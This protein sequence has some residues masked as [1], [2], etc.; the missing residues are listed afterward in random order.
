MLKKYLLL[1]LLLFIQVLLFAQPKQ[2]IDSL[3]NILKSK[4]SLEKEAETLIAL[5]NVY[6]N[7]DIKLGYEYAEKAINMAAKTNNE[8]LKL[9]AKLCMA[10]VYRFV[11]RPD[12]CIAIC[13][14]IMSIARKKNKR[15]LTIRALQILGL[16]YMGLGQKNL[17]LNFYLE[18]IEIYDDELFKRETGINQWIAALYADQKKYDE[19]LFYLKKDLLIKSKEKN[20]ETAGTLS[21]IGNLYYKQKKYEQALEYYT[22]G[23]EEGKKIKNIYTITYTSNN[24]GLVKFRQKKYEEAILYFEES[25]E[26]A[27]KIKNHRHEGNSYS[28]LA[29]LYR[30]MKTYKKAIEYAEIGFKL[31]KQIKDVVLILEISTILV[32]IYEDINDKENKYLYQSQKANYQDTLIKQREEREFTAFELHQKM[33]YEKKENRE[34]SDRNNVLFFYTIISIIGILS[35]GIIVFLQFKRNK[36]KQE[37]IYQHDIIMTD[38]EKKRRLERELAHSE[39]VRLEEKT[40]FQARQLS[41]QATLLMQK[42]EWLLQ[43]EN[44]LKEL[45]SDM[46][47]DQ[48]RSIRKIFLET[49][50]AISLENDWDNYKNQFEQV[51]P[52]FFI[53]I[54]KRFPKTTN[55]D[56]R[57]AAYLKM[58]L[59]NG[60]IAQMLNITSGSLKVSFNRLKK[61]FELSEEQNLRGFIEEF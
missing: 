53:N 60:E 27:K 52:T 42:N 46:P 47:L 58:R 49:K 13:R 59:T 55:N 23:Y 34:L 61:K 57:L 32:D 35:L 50:E 43:I 37:V 28:N 54:Q 26:S 14:E 51:H 44:K 12:D 38:L 2:K 1:I 40:E 41:G 5:S 18:M 30:E 45:E 22:K 36:L 19:A 48:K 20:S 56:C 24:I 39:Q 6:I 33:M 10:N 21:E 31:A 25:I 3:N 15:D 29:Q 11:S 17:A 16:C 9:F 8:D 4:I 7:R